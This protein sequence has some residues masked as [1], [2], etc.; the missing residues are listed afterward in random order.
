MSAGDALSA[1]VEELGKAS[2]RAAF[3]SLFGLLT[4]LA[5]L[6]Y[7]TVRVGAVEQQRRA[8]AA[9]VDSLHSVDTLLQQ[10]IDQRKQDIAALDAWKA[11]LVSANEELTA[12]V[13]TAAPTAASRSTV[14]RADNAKYAV[15]IY[16][17]GG[18]AETFEQVTKRLEDD[19]YVIT[20]T[21]RFTD[22]PPPNWLSRRSTV[23]YYDNAAADKARVIA[24]TLSRLTGTAFTIAMGAGLGVVPGQA[25]WTF[26]VHY[27]GK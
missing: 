22:P 8:L 18:S 23:L 10:E 13:R 21:G 1:R 2:K 20:Q 6:A 26:F 25:R 14:K 9:E 7:G 15:G 5:A 4:V 12:T 16:A 3:L 27:I 17:F 24:D 11:R 19:G